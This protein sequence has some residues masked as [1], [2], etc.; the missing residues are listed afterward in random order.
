M[1]YLKIIIFAIAF[2]AVIP[3]LAGLVIEEIKAAGRM[4]VDE[5]K[6]HLRLA[7]V[8]RSNREAAQRLK[9]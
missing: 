3:L 9:T 4:P 7:D 1:D 2:I 8:V 5:E 6:Y